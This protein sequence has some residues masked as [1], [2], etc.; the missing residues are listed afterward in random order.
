M[1]V[2]LYNFGHLFTPT[3]R[4]DRHDGVLEEPHPFRF[5]SGPTFFA[6]TLPKEMNTRPEVKLIKN[7]EHKVPRI[8]AK[9]ESASNPNRWSTAVETWVREFQQHRRAESLPPFDSLFK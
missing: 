2:T 6:S 4:Q 9:V 3:I 1:L 8:Q 5:F 7:R